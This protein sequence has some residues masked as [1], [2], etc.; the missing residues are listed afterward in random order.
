VFRYIALAWDDAL[1]IV[2]SSARQFGMELAARSDWQ[3]TVSRPGLQVYITGTKPGINTALPLAAGRGVVL[4]K[5]F[6]RR[7][8]P[9]RT[10][11]AL[12]EDE[13]A[14]I[15]QSAGRTLVNDYWG[16]YIAFLPSSN[17]STVLL[18]DPSGTLPCFLLR[19]EG[20]TIVFSWLEDALDLLAHLRPP[21]VDW[22][23]LQAHIR[24][25][26]L[27]GEDTALEGVS[28]ILAGQCVDLRTGMAAMLWHPVEIARSPAEYSA[29]HA[30]ELLRATVRACTQTWAACY[31][32]LLLRLSGGVD[33]SILASCLAAGNTDTDVICVNYHSPGSDSDERSYARLA[34]T[35][36]GRDLIERER[37]PQF[38]MESL[39][40]VARMPAPVNHIGWMN[41]RTD[42]TLAA[43]H[44]APAMFTGAGGDQLFFELGMWWPIADYL[45]CRGLD[46]GLMS[47]ALD[48]ARLGRVSLWRALALALVDRLHPSSFQREHAN[49]SIMLGRAL[50]E[51]PL[52]R[53][54]YIHPALLHPT[55]LPIGKHMQTL[56]LIHP[57]GYYD[58]FEQQA[59][60]ELVT[61]LLSQPLVELG[62]TLPTYQLTEGGRGRALA[63]RA[64]A[65]DLPA[66]ITTRRSKGGMEEHSLAVLQN[67]LAFARGMLLEGELARQG[68]I[69]RAKVE[70]VLSGRPTSLLGHP[71]QIHSLIGVEAWL[72]RWHRPRRAPAA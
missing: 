55:G 22:Q 67:N 57:L 27:S 72:T 62:L 39:L 13:E 30:A 6:R 16:R 68:F 41:A 33:S 9:T 3:A 18:R 4:G 10:D 25:G 7:G 32:T 54:R 31:D 45:R 5:L 14:K 42:A 20:L 21:R 44:S 36:A 11:L 34:A 17:D 69:D 29:S 47:A 49:R 70:E 51:A 19:H 64:F 61:P 37:N 43:A 52:R 40:G 12:T 48:A 58:P 56:M 2:G 15:L 1:P 65:S 28:Q 50:L 63:R 26:E 60:A 24:L 35:K 71:S 38:D 59:A 8:T 46:S 53:E 23:A 66:Q